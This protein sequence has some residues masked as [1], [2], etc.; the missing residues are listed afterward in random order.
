VMTP[1][2]RVLLRHGAAVRRHDDDG[3]ESRGRG[4]GRGEARVICNV[5]QTRKEAVSMKSVHAI[6]MVIVLATVAHGHG[7]AAA[8]QTRDQR[9]DDAIR[10]VIAGITEAFNRHDAK[11]WIRFAT[12]DAQLVTVR[13]ES[14]TG[15]AEIERGLTTLFQTRNKNATVRVLAL[16]VRL[17]RPDVT[18]DRRWLRDL[19]YRRYVHSYQ[20]SEE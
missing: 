13:G 6:L 19:L 17:I 16:T 8:A 20:R 7:V 15:V 9:E 11:A 14:M 5:R 2:R 10:A 18:R 3:R 12:S 1:R 4:V